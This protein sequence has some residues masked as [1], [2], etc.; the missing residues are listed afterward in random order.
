MQNEEVKVVNAT[1]HP[2]NNGQSENL[3]QVLHSTAQAFSAVMGGLSDEVPGQESVK[4]QEAKGFL[5]KLKGYMQSSAF[6]KD[7]N[8]TAQKYGVPPKKLAQNFFTKALGTVGDILGIAIN[9]VCNAGKMIINL[10][11]TVAHGIVELIRSI[12]NGLASIVTFNQTCHV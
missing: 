11:S 5:N 2:I 6:E 12:A 7:I 8:E 3:Q 4:E 9:V 1:V 10:A